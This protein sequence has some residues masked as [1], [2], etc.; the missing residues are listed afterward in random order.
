MEN[1]NIY[2]RL[3]YGQP[4]SQDEMLEALAELIAWREMVQNVSRDIDTP[5]D[6]GRYVSDLEDQAG[7]CNNEDHARFDDYKEFFD[8]CIYALPKDWPCAEPWDMN[9]RSVITEAIENG[10]SDD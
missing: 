1:L 7:G 9:L 2:E 3:N 4:V 8:D 10:S 5:E 6:F